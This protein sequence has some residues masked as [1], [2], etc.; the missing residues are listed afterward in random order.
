M[1]AGSTVIPDGASGGDLDGVD[2]WRHSGGDGDGAGEEGGGV[3]W[4]AGVVE[5]G[6]GDGVCLGPEVELDSVSNWDSHVVWLESQRILA[7]LD[8]VDTVGGS[9]GSCSSLLC[10]SSGSRV[11]S[12]IVVL[13]QSDGGESSEKSDELHVD[14]LM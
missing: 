7:D 5:G 6:L 4:L 1:R 9:S 8:D 10:Q 11:T 13:C 12:A 14:G 2:C 3:E